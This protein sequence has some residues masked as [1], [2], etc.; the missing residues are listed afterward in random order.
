M[1]EERPSKITGVTQPYTLKK[2]KIQI[3]ILIPKQ[4]G[5]KAGA[6]SPKPR[7]F[8]P[9]WYKSSVLFSNYIIDF[10]EVIEKSQ[11]NWQIKWCLKTY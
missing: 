8:S 4:F 11:Q 10:I 3:Q 5:S 7:W 2:H 6:R 9:T 1:S